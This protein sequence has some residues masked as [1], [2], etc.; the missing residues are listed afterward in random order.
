MHL[1]KRSEISMLNTLELPSLLGAFFIVGLQS[2]FLKMKA[3]LRGR[4]SGT[5]SGF[6]YLFNLLT[7]M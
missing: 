7:V 3:S 2:F 4:V 6:K 5:L 1:L